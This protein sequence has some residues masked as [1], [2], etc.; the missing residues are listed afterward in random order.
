MQVIESRAHGPPHGRD[1]GAPGRTCA[2][3]GR[4]SGVYLETGEEIFVGSLN[5]WPEGTFATTN[6][7]ESKWDPDVPTGQKLVGRV[8]V[9]DG[10]GV[11][12]LARTE[13]RG[14]ERRL[15]G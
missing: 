13:N 8:K 9:P 5:D 1:R 10:L 14:G 11:V 15:V 7:F 3:N 6:K 2:G 4:P 12:K